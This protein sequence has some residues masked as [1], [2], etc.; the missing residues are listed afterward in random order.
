MH[1]LAAH[2]VTLC[3]RWHSKNASV[4]ESPSLSR[5]AFSARRT[6]VAAQA[7][8]VGHLSGRRRGQRRMHGSIHA[9]RVG[10]FGTLADS[11]T[12]PVRTHATKTA[13]GR[14]PPT[15]AGRPPVPARR[16][17]RVVVCC[18]RERT[19]RGQR[20]RK[21]AVPRWATCKVLPTNTIAQRRAGPIMC[22]A[23]QQ[24]QLHSANMDTA[25]AHK[26]ILQTLRPI[27]LRLCVNG[28]RAVEGGAATDAHVW[29]ASR[30]WL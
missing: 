18:R 13:L 2:R 3:F 5:G 29:V 22:C 19:R 1:E 24:Q 12:E 17:A 20:P 25:C 16:E 28:G 8:S 6:R 15:M 30:L 23:E 10:A 21:L 26:H 27:W 7:E 14:R 11:S 9:V 4:L